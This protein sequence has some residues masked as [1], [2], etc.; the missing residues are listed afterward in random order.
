MGMLMVNSSKL[1]E[2]VEMNGFEYEM[3]EEVF[4]G[5][6]SELSQFFDKYP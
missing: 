5:K 4:G 1:F 2:A 6:S 3:G